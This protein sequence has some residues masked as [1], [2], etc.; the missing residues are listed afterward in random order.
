MGQSSRSAR[1]HACRVSR[2]TRAKS[3]SIKLILISTFR[4]KILITLV[5]FGITKSFI[6]DVLDRRDTHKT[7]G[8]LPLQVASYITAAWISSLILARTYVKKNMAAATPP[9]FNPQSYE[10]RL[11]RAMERCGMSYREIVAHSQKE[12]EGIWSLNLNVREVF[13]IEG[14]VDPECL[15]W[16]YDIVVKSFSDGQVEMQFSGLD[17]Q[18]RISGQKKCRILLEGRNERV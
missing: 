15:E 18:K 12:M 6:Q 9:S 8:N 5:L 3:W 2:T 11:V 14:L 1:L 17:N 10:Y 13:R 16:A 7:R 4:Q